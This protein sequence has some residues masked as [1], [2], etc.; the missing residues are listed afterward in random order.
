[1]QQD[2]V[3]ATERVPVAFH[4]EGTGTGVLSWGQREIWLAM[5]HQR[6]HLAIGGRK[7]LPPGTTVAQ[8]AD[9]LCYL[10]T[11]YPSMR[12][13]LRFP[14][15]APE[16]P[17]QELFDSGVIGLE[18]FDVAEGEDAEAVAAAVERR[19]KYEPY[20]L[21]GTWP[22]RMGVTRQHG[23][24]THMIILLAHIVSD[25]GGGSLMLRE[26]ETR[27]TGPVPG[28]QQLE[29]ARWQSSPDGLRH[30]A[31][32]LRYWADLLRR[33]PTRQLPEPHEPHEPRHW[34]GELHSPALPIAV[35][36]VA[37]RTGADS[38]AVLMALFAASLA[39]ITGI[40][41]VVI[42][43]VVHN[44]FRAQLVGVMCMVAQ[45]G[46]CALDVAGVGF[47]QA[48]GRAERATMSA[49][50]YAYFD[51]WAL[52]DLIAEVA[53]ERDP[54]L[55]V[56]TFFNDRRMGKGTHDAALP[57]ASPETL[58]RTAAEARF[59]WTD[60]QDAPIE[61]LFLHV[62]D[63]PGW[64]Q[65]RVCVDTAFLRPEDAERLV[66]SMQELAV[67]AALTPDTPTGVP[68]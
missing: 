58:A 20:D 7:A 6:D 48:V 67:A 45:A 14:A 38:S 21:A 61:R 18:V 25:A 1:M 22:V 9:E 31:R 49:S 65:L 59:G 11:R 60:K 33:I 56:A 3:A 39:R 47:D 30:N 28:M 66:W 54:E 42:R 27:E 4:G 57:E 5:V 37:R 43:P 35:N 44:R 68:R 63:G 51:P 26:V 41:P 62:D 12:T 55:D 15:D 8:I 34:A 2:A 16:R 17:T 53:A 32:T 29:Q 19:Y 10:M 13:L 50:K 64:I 23:E 52:N 40:N 24:A 36:A 46:C